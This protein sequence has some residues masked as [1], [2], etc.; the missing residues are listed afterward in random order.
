VDAV[1]REKVQP[2]VTS[3]EEKAKAGTELLDSLNAEPLR[4]YQE[5]TDDLFGEDAAK[6]VTGEALADFYP[7]VPGQETP[8]QTE[9]PQPRRAEAQPEGNDDPILREIR[10]DYLDRK[11]QAEFEALVG[12]LRESEAAKAA[13]EGR[14]PIP[15]K[16]SLFKPFL[17]AT[18]GDVEQAWSRYQ[19][20]VDTAKTELLGQEPPPEP[21]PTLGS[22]S[23]GGATP[24]THTEKQYNGDVGA[25]IEDWAADLK[26]DGQTIVPE[27]PA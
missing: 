5:L 1:L 20:F 10:E 18:D 27:V 8:P 3:V 25:A 19:S 6:R 16:D 2:Y 23:S 4:T 17:H 14:D 24:P 7:A 22:A 26:R 13:A 15:L 11:N 9:T 21:P 12:E